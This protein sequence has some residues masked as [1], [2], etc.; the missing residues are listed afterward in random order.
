MFCENNAAVYYLHLAG[1]DTI[2][3]PRE[4]E[5]DFGTHGVCSV[6]VPPGWLEALA[7]WRG[8]FE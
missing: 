2:F 1:L 7:G 3:E 5:D 6:P 8:I 4:I